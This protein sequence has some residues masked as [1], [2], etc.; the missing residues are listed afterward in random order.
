[1]CVLKR[2]I[3]STLKLIFSTMRGHQRRPLWRRRWPGAADSASWGLDPAPPRPQLRVASMPRRG[4]PSDSPLLGW[5]RTSPVGRRQVVLAELLRLWPPHPRR[6][7]PSFACVRRRSSPR[8]RGS[9]PSLAPRLEVPVLLACGR[10]T[11]VP[12]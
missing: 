2:T 7:R 3:F 9:S 10:G 4:R 5:R 6:P 11:V 12:A 1:M 8:G